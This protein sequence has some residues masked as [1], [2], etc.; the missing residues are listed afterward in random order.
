MNGKLGQ[1]E[2]GTSSF[3]TLYAAPATLDHAVANVLVC[4]TNNTEVQVR[5]AVAMTLAPNTADFIEYDYPLPARGHL[6]RTALVL[7][8]G[9][10]ILIYASAPGVVCRAHGFEKGN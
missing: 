8:P 1:A 7:S 5:I 4:N 6:E 9:E 2:A 10:N 3:V